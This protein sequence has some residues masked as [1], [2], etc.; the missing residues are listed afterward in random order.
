MKKIAILLLV[1]LLSISCKTESKKEMKKE[2]KFPSELAKVFEKHGGIDQWRK[3]KTLS[4][5]RGEEAHT[6]DLWSRK[7]VVNAPNYSLGYDGDE[8]WLS[9]KDSTA[10]KSNPSFYYNL[11]FYFYTMP[12]VLADDGILYEKIAP[13]V[14]K[15]EE[16]PGF[17]ISFTS[18]KGTSPDDNYV[19]YYNAETYQMEWL[20]YTVTYFSKKASNKFNLI[21]YNDWESVNGFKLPKSITWY[22]KEDN[23]SPIEP[24]GAATEF[25]LSIISETA[26]DDSFFKKATEE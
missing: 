23:G 13:L 24:A 4:F 21:R 2:E 12:F 26:L 19:I 17:K 14:F 6:T 9:Q 5:N 10:F 18:E 22:K 16:Y 8:V 1:V 15:G 25:S 7:G 3:M 11:Y 20:G